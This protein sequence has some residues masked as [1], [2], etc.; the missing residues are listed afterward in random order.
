MRRR[1]QALGYPE[2]ETFRRAARVR[3]RC[4]PSARAQVAQREAARLRAVCET[5]SYAVDV[6]EVELHRLLG[7]PQLLRRDLRKFERALGDVLE[8]LELALGDQP[9]WAGPARPSAK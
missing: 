5:P 1:L 4:R 6:R 9:L 3:A 8:D 7:D 2:Q